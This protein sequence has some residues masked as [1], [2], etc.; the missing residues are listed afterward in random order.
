M[1][2]E[3]TKLFVEDIGVDAVRL[4]ITQEVCVLE[5]VTLSFILAQSTTTHIRTVLLSTM[6]TTTLCYYVL[7]KDAFPIDVKKKRLLFYI[8]RFLT[9]LNVVN[10]FNSV[11][12]ASWA[13][14][15]R[16]SKAVCMSVCVSA[17]L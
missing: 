6:K 7:G 4:E 12:K 8:T 2:F 3:R 16:W 14:H 10:V 9:F 1:Q 17:C 5:P 11:G 13:I 15:I